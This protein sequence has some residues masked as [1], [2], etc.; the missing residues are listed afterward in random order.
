MLRQR[1]AVRDGGRNE[2][3]SS[4][5]KPS[6]DLQYSISIHLML[7]FESHDPEATIV[8]IE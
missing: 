5:S 4:F 8:R 1:Q 7:I 2:C 3:K 6:S